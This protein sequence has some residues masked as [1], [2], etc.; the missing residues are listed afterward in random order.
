MPLREILRVL[1]APRK[2]FEEIIQNPRYISP[3][4][5]MI[6]FIVAN[7]VSTYPIFVR[8]YVEKTFP[9]LKDEWTEDV[10]LWRTI[11]GAIPTVNYA[12]RI[13][14]DIYGNG[15][16]EFTAKDASEISIHLEGIGS[17]N[18]S[19]QNGYSKLYLRVK[20]IKPNTPPK[21]VSIYLFSAAL[22][23]Y[24]Y[25]DL[26]ESFSNVTVNVWNN[27]TLPLA[28]EEWLHVGD[29]DWSNIT[30]LRIVLS[31]PE[32][33]DITVLVDGLF[34]GGIYKPYV[35]NVVSYLASYASFSFMQFVI[36]WVFLGGIIHIMS[37]AFKANTAWRVTLVL[38][39]CALITIVIQAV[40][41]TVAFSI[42]FPIIKYPIEFVGGVKGEGER[43]YAK[44]LEETRLVNEIYGYVQIATVLWT[45]V[46]CG[47]AVR[48]STGFSWGKSLLISVVAYFAAT[49]IE[50]FLGV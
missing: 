32:K 9:E 43:A 29:A 20:W 37:K 22:S 30:G 49:I 24:F 26:T 28:D 23:N 2:A 42:T 13:V 5:V 14:G 4:T 45:V 35:E 46:L 40:V 7:V 38:V 19:S 27:L 6:L 11:D 21:S 12:D 15:S 1:Y 44:I 18:C 10:S 50:G 39:G 31:W 48:S 25:R 16:I 47:I 3:I 17:I 33:S 8:T 41:N 36:R 34:F